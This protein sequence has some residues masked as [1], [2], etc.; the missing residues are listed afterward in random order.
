MK[1][2]RVYSR[3]VGNHERNSVLRRD[4]VRSQTHVV[5]LVPPFRA[6]LPL[7]VYMQQSDA[8]AHIHPSIKQQS[9]LMCM[10]QSDAQP[11]IIHSNTSKLTN[12]LSV[13]VKM[14]VTAE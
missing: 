14:S 8:H 9:G 1:G 12:F 11:I 5:D 10:Q 6:L 4:E 7:P 3:C 13:F 2:R